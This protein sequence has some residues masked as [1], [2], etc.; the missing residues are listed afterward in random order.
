MNKRERSSSVEGPA[1]HSNPADVMQQRDHPKSHKEAY[2]DRPTLDDNAKNQ[3]S[4]RSHPSACKSV[5]SSTYPA[6]ESASK[7]SL[8]DCGKDIDERLKP[9]DQTHWKSSQ[10][11]TRSVSMLVLATLLDLVNDSLFVSVILRL[12][13]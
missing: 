3:P 11:F 6:S 1:K 5:P 9:N 4:E 2:L 12:G 8:P 7:K 13:V 10:N